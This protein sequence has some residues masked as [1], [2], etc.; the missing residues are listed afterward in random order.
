MRVFGAI[1]ELMIKSYQLP[2]T[3]AK[4]MQ[5]TQIRDFGKPNIK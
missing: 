3:Q 2:F 5:F 4:K 1:I